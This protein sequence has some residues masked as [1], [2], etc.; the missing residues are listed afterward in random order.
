[1]HCQ[2]DSQYQKTTCKTT[3]AKKNPDIRCS[4]EE[5][6]LARPVDITMARVIKDN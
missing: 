1:M 2:T 4:R 5:H 3:R 6:S